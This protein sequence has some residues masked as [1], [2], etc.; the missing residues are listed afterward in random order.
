MESII[1][2]RI[3]KTKRDRKTS[4]KNIPDGCTSTTA[5]ERTSTIPCSTA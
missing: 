4:K 2:D 1:C 5:G 3:I